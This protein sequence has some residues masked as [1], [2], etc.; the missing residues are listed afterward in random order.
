[1]KRKKVVFIGA[2]GTALNI[3]EQVIDSGKRYNEYVEPAGIIIDTYKKGTI[4][5]GIPVLGGLKDIAGYLADND[6]YFI[7]ALYKPEK[8]QERYNLLESLNIPLNRFLNFFHPS[9]CVSKSFKCGT[10]N[11]ILGNSTVHS[12]VIFGNFNII[13]SNVVIEHDTV[14]GDGNFLA[15]GSCVGSRVKIGNHCFIGLNSSIRE[16]VKVGNNLFVGMH[17]LVLSDFSDCLVAGVPAVK[18]TKNFMR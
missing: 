1:M 4:I 3:I 6:I 18:M 8:L 5:S 10:G 11:V 7:F 12:N 15:S 13:N 17:S 14:L 9:S 2:A 16:N